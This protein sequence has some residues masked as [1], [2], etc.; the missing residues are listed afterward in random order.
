MWVELN[1]EEG[2][3]I[4]GNSLRL[5]PLEKMSTE[6]FF[7]QLSLSPAT[8]LKSNPKFQQLLTPLELELVYYRYNEPNQ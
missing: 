4:T 1:F 2:L 3:F 8:S 5:T 6:R 7:A